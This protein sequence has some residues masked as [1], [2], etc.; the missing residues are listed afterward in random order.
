M[1]TDI[2]LFVVFL[3]VLIGLALPLGKYIANVFVGGSSKLER[4]FAPIECLCYRLT[5]VNQ[6]KEKEMG[7]KQYTVAVVLFNLLGVLVLFMLQMLQ[8]LLPLNPQSFSAVDT[9]HLALN[10][11]ISFMTNTNWQGYGG[12]S[13]LS[14]FT[15]MAGLTVQ[16]FLSAA[17]GIV[18]AIVLMRGLTYQAKNSLGNFYQDMVRCIVRIL[19]PL[20]IVGS[21]LLMQQGVIQNLNEYVTA[22][23]LEGT[24]QTIAMGPVASQEAIKELGTNGGGFFNVNSAHPFENSTPITNFLEMF[25][26]L[27]IPLALVFT[28]GHMTANRKQGFAISG[29]MV[30]LFV[31]MLS[32]NYISETYGNPILANMN[33][34][35]PTSM[36]G[37]EVRFGIGDSSLFTTVTTAAS[38]GAVNGMHDSLTPIGGLVPMLQMMLGEIVI[39]GV[40]AGFYGIMLYIFIT[41]F[42]VGLMVGRTPEYLGKK[43]EA[44]E[45]K[46]VMT[47][48]LLPSCGILLF[49]AISCV[50]ETGVASLNNSG[51][52]GLS[53][54]FY[55]YASAFGNNGSA[56]AGLTANTLFYDLM[57][58]LAMFIGRFGVIIPIM[59]VAGSMV[60]KKVTPAGLGTFDTGSSTFV[61]LLA[62]VVLV[63]G[64]LTFLPALAL[65]PIVE[66]LLMLQN[67]TF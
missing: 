61:V 20:A 28:F 1:I 57:L 4:V 26:I 63:V 51:P 41:V 16:N 23:T 31:L 49:S 10:T 24:Q 66:Q 33:I 59:M 17:T 13:T 27:I 42:I 47:A 19:L 52:H 6:S 54:I 56:F 9:W 43:I 29:A 5:G 36:E 12:E 11:A 48:L 21:V 53:E 37:K 46:L 3:I 14:Y 25:Y 67:I 44:R 22:N 65:G 60:S 64:A 8:H 62:G 45:M 30:T 7:W 50:L 34:A 2:I 55:A 38:C 35:E 40:G 32:V 18:V 15:Q 39:G 58:G